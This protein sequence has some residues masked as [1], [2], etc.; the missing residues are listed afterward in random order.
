V[1]LLKKYQAFSMLTRIV[2]NFGVLLLLL[3]ALALVGHMIIPHDHH[4]VESD[5]LQ[6]GTCPASNNSTHP[7]NGLPFHCHAF[8]DLSTEKTVTYAVIRNSQCRDFVTISVF[9]LA[10]TD[11]QL[12][13]SRFLEI[14]KL[15]VNSFILELS[16]LR[17]PPLIG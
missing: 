15:P 2:R 13:C 4:L 14:L 11:L 17:A 1:L 7:H 12:P 3:A 10:V 5:F 8:N 16:S 9:D 6:E